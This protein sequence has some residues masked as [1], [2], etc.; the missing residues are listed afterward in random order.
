M[1]KLIRKNKIRKELIQQFELGKLEIPTYQ[2]MGEDIDPKIT[3]KEQLGH[4]V[5]EMYKVKYLKSNQ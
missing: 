4:L 5:N 1:L 3:F 2:V